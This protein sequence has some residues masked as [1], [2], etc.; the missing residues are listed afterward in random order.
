[1]NILQMTCT[2]L[3][4]LFSL[5]LSEHAEICLSGSCLFHHLKWRNRAMETQ[6]PVLACCSEKHICDMGFGQIQEMMGIPSFLRT[7]KWM[8]KILKCQEMD[9]FLHSR[10]T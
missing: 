2:T 1:M 8:V 10:K 3:N 6:I 4:H 5:A 7:M 9:P